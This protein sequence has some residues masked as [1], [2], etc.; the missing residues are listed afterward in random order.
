MKEKESATPTTP[1]KRRSI[2][3]TKSTETNDYKHGNNDICFMSNN[4]P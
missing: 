2:S 1:F 3:N 4:A